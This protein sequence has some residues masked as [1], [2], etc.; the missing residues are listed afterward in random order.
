MGRRSY[1]NA[2]LFLLLGSLFGI[3]FV[4]IKAG[5][6]ELPPVLFASFRFGV[7]VPL[8][9]AFIFLRYDTWLPQ[10]RG[11][12]VGV[13]VGSVVLVAGTNAFLF[14]GQQGVTSAAASVVFAL[15]PVLAPVFAVILIN[16]KLDFLDASGIAIGLCGV[17]VLVE[18]TQAAFLAGSAVS[19]FIV[20]CGAACNALGSVL[21]KQVNP[22]MERIPLTTWSMAGG[23]LLLFVSS[24][25][26]GESTAGV[27]VSRE[28]VFAILLLGIPSTAIAYPIYFTL[29][30][31]IGPV[32]TN[33][34]SY[35]VPVVAAIVGWIW[36]SEQVTVTTVAGFLI[37]VAGVVLLERSVVRAELRSLARGT[38]G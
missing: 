10:N 9:L 28:L 25:L 2:A 11:D 34:M 6:A 7:A 23:T 36:L 13:L 35:V 26:I 24:V 4:S 3:A 12:Y 8:L 18:P 21:L 27:T 15:N 22:T 31:R 32:R 14:I 30:G 37:I 38:G 29:I 5:L 19:I 20:L 1:Q 17:I 33:L 16:E